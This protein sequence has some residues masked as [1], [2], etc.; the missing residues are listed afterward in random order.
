MLRGVL[1]IRDYH[2][3]RDSSSTTRICRQAQY[4]THSVQKPAYFPVHF[5]AA[6]MK[7]AA[8]Q[9]IALT[10]RSQW[11]NNWLQRRRCLLARLEELPAMTSFLF[12]AAGLVLAIVAPGLVRILRGPAPADRMM[13]S[14]LIETGGV[15]VL[16]LLAVARKTPAIVD[17][18]LIVALLG[19][20]ASVAFV[21]SAADSEMETPEAPETK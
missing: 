6:P 13:G 15:A 12:G 18:A 21:E 9:S 10:L 20:F 11:S 5:R 2:Y 17:V 16:L 14:Q 19:A 7:R 1:S 3:A 4:E 8:S